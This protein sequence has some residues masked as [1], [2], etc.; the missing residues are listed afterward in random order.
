MSKCCGN[1]FCIALSRTNKEKRICTF[2]TGAIFSPCIFKNI[3]ICVCT[4]L[5]EFM[6]TAFVHSVSDHP[7]TGIISCCNLPDMGTGN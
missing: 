7:G 3:F 5:H 6:C 1:S 4:C 2:S